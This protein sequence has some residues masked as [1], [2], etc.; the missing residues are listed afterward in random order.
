M[1][2]FHLLRFVSK[3][4]VSNLLTQFKTYKAAVED[5]A[6]LRFDVE[7]VDPKHCPLFQN[8]NKTVKSTDDLSWNTVRTVRKF[9]DNEE[10]CWEYVVDSIEKCTSNRYKIF[11]G[12]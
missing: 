11:V 8:N 9:R 1:W 10:F 2:E 6:T 3:D 7:A 12:G 4:Q 5:F